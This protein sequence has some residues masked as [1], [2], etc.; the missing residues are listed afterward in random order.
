MM[1]LIGFGFRT[2]TGKVL[3][4]EKKMM[5]LNARDIVVVQV[6]F[7]FLIMSLFTNEDSGSKIEIKNC[8]IFL[9]FFQSW[10]FASKQ[11]ITQCRSKSF[12]FGQFL[13]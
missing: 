10:Q 13:F 1:S 2:K 4:P 6:G 8:S 3:K 11:F 12:C 7:R 5:N 9:E